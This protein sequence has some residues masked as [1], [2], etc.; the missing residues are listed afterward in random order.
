MIC[1]EKSDKISKNSKAF[2]SLKKKS[3]LNHERKFAKFAFEC[4]QTWG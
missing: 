1:E 3:E 4:L 2:F